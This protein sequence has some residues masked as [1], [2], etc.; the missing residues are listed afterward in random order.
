MK[1][2]LFLIDSLRGGG[3]EKV[4]V[5]LVN[6]MD[7]SEFDI[8]VET[9]FFNGVN[10]Q[11]LNEKVKLIC[12]NAP[13]FK[14]VSHV[15]KY[16]P[17]KLLYKFFIG[18]EKYDILVAYMHGAPAKVISG[19]TDSSVKKFAW[20]HIN[21]MEHGT[22][23]KFYSSRE[24]TINSYSRFNNIVAVSDS[25]KQAFDSA[26]G[27]SDKSVVRYNTN[28]TAR[29]KEMAQEDFSWNNDKFHICTMG[30]LS[31]QKGFDRLVSIAK[32]L[33]D[34][35]YDFEIHILGKGSTEEELK[36]QIQD[37]NTADKVF[38]DGFSPNPY[39][40]LSKSD[41]FVCSSLFEGLSTAMSEAVILGIPVVTTD[42]SGA[43][44]VLG[45]NNEYGIV[46]QNDENAL[47]QALKLVLSDK[48]MYNY[49]KS[50]VAE[51]ADFFDTKATVKAVENLF[52][53]H[54]ED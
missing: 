7:Y 47:Y 36:K 44:E 26:T 48:N 12:K 38:L 43:K 9:M 22:I 15:L 19:C 49:Y 45:L 28:D 23:W 30:R 33:S 53:N 17:D 27:L 50:K 2:I 31:E 34:E 18:K 37:S 16:I 42:V 11:F 39:K 51:R 14:G 29:I 21:E 13:Y 35:G 24:K 25:V 41:L 52:I 3:A 8:T 10:S 4:L 32:R 6:N 1:K 46:T 54:T 40:V 20:I 5:N